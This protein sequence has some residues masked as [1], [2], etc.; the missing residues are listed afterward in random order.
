MVGLTLDGHTVAYPFPI[1]EHTAVVNDTVG[2]QD[3][4]IFYAS[5]TLS[6]FFGRGYS[7]KRAVGST[8]VFDPNLDGQKLTFSQDESSIVDEQTGSSWTVLGQAVEGPLAGKSLAPVVHAN[9]FWFAWAVFFPET[10]L[11]SSDAVSG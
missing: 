8:G 11:R 10:E 3:L 6:A 5:D 9:H 7:E 2:S 4:V 1:F